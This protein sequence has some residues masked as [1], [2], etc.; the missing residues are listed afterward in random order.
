MKFVAL[1][2]FV[3]GW[4]SGLASFRAIKASC[5]LGAFAHL[6]WLGLTIGS[7]ICEFS[8]AKKIHALGIACRA[9]SIVGGSLGVFCCIEPLHVQWVVM[10][11][12]EICSFCPTQVTKRWLGKLLF[13]LGC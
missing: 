5:R 13:S 9:T 10:S 6:G 11:R 3:K 7:L 8:H 4:G 12:T 2:V 1:G